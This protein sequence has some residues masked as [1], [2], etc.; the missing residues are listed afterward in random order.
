M[1]E[2]L[3]PCPFCGIKRKIKVSEDDMFYVECLKCGARTDYYICESDVIEAWNTR[4]PDTELVKAL[5][6]LL[7]DTDD[8]CSVKADNKGRRH[9]D[10]E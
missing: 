5:E 8:R 7:N 9:E 6:D 10:G 1:S 4:Q 3:A 2:K